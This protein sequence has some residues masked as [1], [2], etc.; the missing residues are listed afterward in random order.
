[1]R[2]YSRTLFAA[3]LSGALWS[4]PYGAEN[5]P[6]TPSPPETRPAAVRPSTVSIDDVLGWT[7]LRERGLKVDTSFFNL[8]AVMPRTRSIDMIVLHT[9]ESGDA[10]ERNILPE[11]SEKWH[12]HYVIGRSGTVYPVVDPEYWA[13]HADQSIWNGVCDLDENSI[14]IEFV[15]NAVAEQSALRRNVTN[16]QYA[17]GKVLKAYLME[18][19]GIPAD[20]VLGHTQVALNY[21]TDTRGRKGDPGP[22]FSYQKLDLPNNA[23]IPD[24]DIRIGLVR[25]NEDAPREHRLTPGQLA[26]FLQKK[27]PAAQRYD[28]RHRLRAPIRTGAHPPA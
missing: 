13:W 28:N 15:A 21:A 8:A 23:V 11:I 4:L 10:Y 5:P 7:E 6:T 26:A 18:R 9:T 17:A 24:P 12:A 22:A 20:R 25:W 19:Y 27:L 14:G 16:A 1:M 2:P 3:L